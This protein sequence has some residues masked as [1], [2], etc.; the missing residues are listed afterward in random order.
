MTKAFDPRS[1]DPVLFYVGPPVE[2]IPD[3]D[4][5][6]NHLARIAWAKLGDRPDSPLDVKDKDIERLANELIASGS[7]D[8]KPAT[9]A[10][11]EA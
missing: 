10:K 9:P 2:G 7:Y 6:A 1:A 4:L 3:T 5:S 8:T 11:P